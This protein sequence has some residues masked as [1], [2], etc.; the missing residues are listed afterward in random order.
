MRGGDL[1]A[2]LGA[3]LR[4]GSE[5]F[6]TGRLF[7]PQE[8]W[9]KEAQ[10]ATHGRFWF[11]ASAKMC[12]VHSCSFK[13]GRIADFIPRDPYVLSSLKQALPRIKCKHRTG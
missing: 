11:P 4:H 8:L 6:L 1:N 7:D 2:E 13:H 10:K 3:L 9:K 5:C 12:L